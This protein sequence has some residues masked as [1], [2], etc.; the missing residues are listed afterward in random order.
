[1]VAEGSEQRREGKKE[2][3]LNL[4][5]YT[6][7]ENSEAESSR[8]GPGATLHPFTTALGI[9]ARSSLPTNLKGTDTTL[10]TNA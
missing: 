4:R 8:N 3:P 9:S 5:R 10:D 1:M 6:N 2:T 7:A